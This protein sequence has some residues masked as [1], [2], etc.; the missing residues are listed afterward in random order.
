MS[1]VVVIGAGFGGLAAVKE[2]ADAPVQVTIVDRHNFHTFQ[3]L[4]YQVATAG[5]NAA[6]VAYAVRGIFQRQRNVSFRQAEVIGVDWPRSTLVLDDGELHFDHL[7]VAAG[8]SAAYFG[9]DGAEQ[10]G[11]PLYVLEDAIR[12]RNHMLERFEAADADPS[13]VDEGALC[14]VVVGGGPTGVEVA[15]ALSEL[16]RMVL[17][18]D[19]PRLDMGKV[20]IVLVEMADVLLQPFSPASQQHARERLADMG[21]DVRT[22][23]AV[24][25][26]SPTDV[27]LKSG[28]VLASHTLVWAA[29]VRANP[30]ADALGVPTGRSGRIVV[31]PDLRIDGHPNAYAV[32]DVAASLGPDGAVLPMLAPVAM[33]GGRHVARQ[34]RSGRHKPFRYR[35]KGTMATIGRRAAVAELPL[36]VRL[37]GTPAWLAWLGLHLVTL[38]GFRNRLSV[39]LNWAWNYVTWD[40]GPRLIIGSRKEQ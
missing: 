39:F 15:G 31:G 25:R 9:I 32:G 21:V 35:D 4:L 6:D 28:E 24:V 16:F 34:I 13:L 37:S 2:L 33:Q 14:F 23:E 11:F 36:H 8:A 7:V 22:N 27:E 26:V 10:N 18:K 12:L 29:G 30:L 17:R 1:D 38:V 19:F 5:L 20:R 3:P 40:R